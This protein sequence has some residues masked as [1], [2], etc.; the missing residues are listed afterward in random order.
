MKINAKLLIQKLP[1]LGIM[2]FM[3]FLWILDINP[4]SYLMLNNIDLILFAISFYL[5]RKISILYIIFYAFCVKD[6]LFSHQFTGLAT[7]QFITCY[8]VF[9]RTQKMFVKQTFTMI[10]MHFMM[11]SIIYT[12]IP[13]IVFYAKTETLVYNQS[14]KIFIATNAWLPILANILMKKFSLHQNA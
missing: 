6:I 2:F 8:L 14:I 4:I 12:I 13:I 1:V 7:M 9:C 11:I 3:L 5:G 10:W